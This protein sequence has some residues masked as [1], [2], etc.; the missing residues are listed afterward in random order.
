MTVNEIIQFLIQHGYAVLFVWILVE[1][2]G[3]PLPG[4]PLLLAA[5][6]LAGEGLLS[7]PPAFGVAVLASLIGNILWY[8]V[9]RRRGNSVLSLLC[10]LS[11]N[12][13][14]CV[15]RT[16]NLFSQHG[17]R[18]LLL[19]KFIPG[20]T[21]IAPPLAGMIR[22]SLVRFLVFGGLGVCLWAGFFLGLGYLISDQIEEIALY[23]A[24]MGVFLGVLLFG[25]LAAYIVWKYAQRR[26]FMRQLRMA[27]ITPEELKEKMD[28][29][30]DIMIL[31]VR[32]PLELDAEPGIIPGALNVPLA[33]LGKYHHLIPRDRELILYCN[34]P[35]EA[36]SA[37]AALQLRQHGIKRVRPLEGGFPE[38]RRHAYP[39]E[40][41]GNPKAGSTLPE[42]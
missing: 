36:S 21:T 1:Q 38:W 28:S 17:E 26:R 30:E 4:A 14:S 23:A 42:K 13:D 20:L 18:S 12:P 29:G 15:Q 2:I 24:R 8:Q 10:R 34:C 6:A 39:V 7:F 22:M 19:A 35:N 32:H 31:D 33:E 41:R 5:G 3:L 11:L 40:A 37:M 9:G 16:E 27:R 25:S